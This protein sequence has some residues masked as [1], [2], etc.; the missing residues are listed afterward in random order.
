MRA[1]ACSYTPAP[2]TKLPKHTRVKNLDSCPSADMRPPASPR[3]RKEHWSNC[4][5]SRIP[6]TTN[7]TASPDCRPRQTP[8]APPLAVSRQSYGPLV[9][10]GYVP[11]T[12]TDQGPSG[13]ALPKPEEQPKLRRAQA[14]V[15]RLR[16]HSRRTD[17]TSSYIV[18]S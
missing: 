16:G 2:K 6:N 13:K 3:N 11:Q 10:S 1:L 8:L 18:A 17:L 14:S 7:G 12:S 5:L 4:R 9:V 15:K